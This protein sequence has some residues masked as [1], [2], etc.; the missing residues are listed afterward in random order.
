MLSKGPLLRNMSCGIVLYLPYYN[1]KYTNNLL[2]PK[3]S[4]VLHHIWELLDNYPDLNVVVVIYHCVKRIWRI[5]ATSIFL[6]NIYAI[7]K[8]IIQANQL[9]YI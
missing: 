9:I 2:D 1:Y 3:E 7:M 4:W 5:I 6:Y 8:N